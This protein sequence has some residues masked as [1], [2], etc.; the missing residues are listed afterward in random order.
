MK[1]IW[2]DI[3]GY[4][5]IYQVSNLGRIKSFDRHRKTMG[6]GIRL[7]KGKIIKHVKK[8]IGYAQVT[9]CDN[10]AI[11]KSVLVHRII[12]TAFI[13]N[14]DNL[15]QVNHK[16]SNRCNN[17]IDNLEWV[18]SREN[19]THRYKKEIKASKYVGVQFRKNRNRWVSRT[20]IGGKMVTIGS[21]KDEHSAHLAYV[22]F[23]SRN[24]IQNKYAA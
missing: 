11:K 13:P 1:E 9:L 6:E 19:Q 5:G 10:N 18:S 15:S 23:L 24:S 8:G 17:T 22:A 2:K 16:D 21:F 4:E 14:P 3:E 7:V 12:A 20:S